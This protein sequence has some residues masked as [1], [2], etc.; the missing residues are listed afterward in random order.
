M[1]AFAVGADVRQEAFDAVKHAH[2][3]DV[4]HP[5][6]IIQR[7]VVDTAAGSH[8]GIVAD[9][10]HVPKGLEC[11]LGRALDA[12]RFGHI[13]DGAAYVGRDFLQAFDGGLQ[14]IRLDIRQHHFHAGLSKRP[15]ERKSD[16]CGSAG[17]KGCLAGKLSHGGSSRDFGLPYLHDAL[18]AASEF[19]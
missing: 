6:P 17:H 18:P 11:S 8:A 9:H 5:S 15:A 14:R 19:P 16:A 7:D 13:A 1:A 12:F 2:Q 3:I 10:M 4:D